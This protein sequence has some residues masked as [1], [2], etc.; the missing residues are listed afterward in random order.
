MIINKHSYHEREREIPA[1]TLLMIACQG[2][3]PEHDFKSACDSLILTGATTECLFVAMLST[4]PYKCVTLTVSTYCVTA[5]EPY[6][7]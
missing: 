2:V 4:W 7:V 5:T 3:N 1:G 6:S